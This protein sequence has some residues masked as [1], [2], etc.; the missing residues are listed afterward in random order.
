MKCAIMRP[1]LL[2]DLGP[3]K[4]DGDNILPASETAGRVRL[5]DTRLTKPAEADHKA[6]PGG[7]GDCKTRGRPTAGG[8]VM[9]SA[10]QF[11]GLSHCRHVHG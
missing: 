5:D 7:A 11:V 1:Q 6:A 3:Q 2:Y 10:P 8:G 4:V 9:L